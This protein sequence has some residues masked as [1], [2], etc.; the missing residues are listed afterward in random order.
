MP[1]VFSIKTPFIVSGIE[2]EVAIV[3]SRGGAFRW[4]WIVESRIAAAARMRG[5]VV[6]TRLMVIDIQCRAVKITW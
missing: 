3:L 5:V 1:P 2:V 4:D 6:Q